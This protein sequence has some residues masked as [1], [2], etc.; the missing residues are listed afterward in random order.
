MALRIGPSPI[1]AMDVRDAYIDG[2]TPITLLACPSQWASNSRSAS[3][4]SDSRSTV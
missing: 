3:D 2:I 4:F 1:S